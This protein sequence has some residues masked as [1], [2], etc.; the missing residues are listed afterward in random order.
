MFFWSFDCEENIIKVNIYIDEKQVSIQRLTMIAYQRN[1][2][3]FHICQL[4][5]HF[6]F[7]TSDPV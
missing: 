1:L 7:V 4:E 3:L 5:L 2:C 6:L